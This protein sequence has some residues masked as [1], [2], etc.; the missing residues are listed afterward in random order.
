MEASCKAWDKWV[1][2]WHGHHWLAVVVGEL[3]RFHLALEVDLAVEVD[4]ALELDLRFWKKHGLL[5]V[6]TLEVDLVL[7]LGVLFQFFLF[8]LCVLSVPS[9]C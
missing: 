9:C 4:L 1:S 3:H 6:G 7:V 8:L 5:V 2:A